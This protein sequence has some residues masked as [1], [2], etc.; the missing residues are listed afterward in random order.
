MRL[1]SRPVR[2]R[3]KARW[4]PLLQ[5]GDPI[6]VEINDE[7]HHGR[8]TEILVDRIAAVVSEP[9]WNGS[10]WF[11]FCDEGL[12]WCQ[13]SAGKSVDAFRVAVALR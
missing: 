10:G 7:V 1:S 12:T 13:G 8:V 2:P 11:H 4:P 9:D 5:L 3:R 6:S